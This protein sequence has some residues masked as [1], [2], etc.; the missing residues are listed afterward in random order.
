MEERR[1]SKM[2]VEREKASPCGRGGRRSLTE[3]VLLLSFASQSASLTA[4]PRGE[5]LLG[6]SQKRGSKRVLPPKIRGKD[7]LGPS[8]LRRQS[9]H[10]DFKF[11]FTSRPRGGPIVHP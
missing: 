8:L 2:I 9:G 1:E 11:S 6:F 4:L 3:R 5:P 10:V 7:L